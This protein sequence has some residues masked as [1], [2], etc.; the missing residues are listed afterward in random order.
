MA[1][2]YRAFGWN[3]VVIDGTKMAEIDKALS[4]LPEVTLNG[5]PTVIICSTKKGQ[6]VKFMMDRP[7]AWHIGGFS[8]ETLKECVDLIKEYTAERLAEV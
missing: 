4:E 6:G 8:D 3:A 2:C 1:D 5:K 7:T